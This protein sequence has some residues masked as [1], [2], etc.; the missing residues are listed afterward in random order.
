MFH[1]RFLLLLVQQ[2]S[3]VHLSCLY[4]SHGVMKEGFRDL[5]FRVLQAEESYHDL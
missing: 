2:T 3:T 1:M 5:L 4:I